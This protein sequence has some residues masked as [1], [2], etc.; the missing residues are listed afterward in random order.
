MSWP[1][2]YWWIPPLVT[3]AGM[4]PLFLYLERR[5]REAYKEFCMMRGFTFERSRHSSPQPYAAVPLFAK[6]QSRRWG[7]TI[8]G[9]WNGRAFTAFEYRYSTGGGKNRHTETVSV[10]QWDGDDVALPRFCCTPEGFWD[11][12]A[13]RFGRQDFDFPED[14]AFSDAYQLQGDDEAAVRGAFT[15][16][17]RRHLLANPHQYVAGAGHELFWWR[18]GRLPKPDDLDALLAEGDGVRRLFLER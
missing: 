14:P 2:A 4:I 17:V 6:G 7:Y 12:L 11:R 9:R 10:M 18:P 8:G 16:E 1:L 5:R 15:A 3:V 13:Q